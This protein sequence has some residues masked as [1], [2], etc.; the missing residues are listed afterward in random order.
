MSIT[1]DNNNNDTN[2]RPDFR[3]YDFVNGTVVVK[4][5]AYIRSGEYMPRWQTITYIDYYILHLLRAPINLEA[6]DYY[7]QIIRAWTLIRTLP[8]GTVTIVKDRDA[9]LNAARATG[10]KHLLIPLKLQSRRFYNVTLD[11]I[12]SWRAE[13]LEE[14]K[15]FENLDLPVPVYRDITIEVPGYQNALL[16]LMEQL[17]GAVG[18]KSTDR[19]QIVRL[20]AESTGDLQNLH[21]HISTNH[22]PPVALV[23]GS[24]SMPAV[25]G[26]SSPAAPGN[27]SIIVD[28]CGV[29]PHRSH[30]L[31][32]TDILIR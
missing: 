10:S 22:C 30:C 6:I 23:A 15:R 12:D 26:G 21:E 9:S 14:Q 25:D 29:T 32:G 27:C 24:A 19:N 13:L 17:I 16:P 18:A 28:L 11:D 2:L 7:K 31:T 3:D 20:I 4:R 1:D 8:G 5:H